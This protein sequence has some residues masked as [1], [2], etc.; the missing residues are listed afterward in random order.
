MI[1]AWFSWLPQRKVKIDNQSKQLKS[2]QNTSYSNAPFYPLS[3][4]N[5][6]ASTTYQSSGKSGQNYSSQ[7]WHDLVMDVVNPNMKNTPID[8]AAFDEIFAGTDLSSDMLKYDLCK[9][10]APAVSGSD[11][12]IDCKNQKDLDDMFK[13]T[14]DW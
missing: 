9:C 2:K 5:W 1:K 4:T 11:L 13:D 10:G 12:C 3:T 7:L 6:Q 14:I 8:Q